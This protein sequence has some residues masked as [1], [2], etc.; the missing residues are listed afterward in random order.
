MKLGMQVGL[1]PGHIALD[2]DPVMQHYLN[3]DLKKC[4]IQHIF[5]IWH[6]VINIYFQM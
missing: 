2:E 3:S 5:L 1:G 6:Q 4:A